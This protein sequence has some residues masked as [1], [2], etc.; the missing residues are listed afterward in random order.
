MALVVALNLWELWDCRLVS[1]AEGDL[2]VAECSG[3]TRIFE[4]HYRASGVTLDLKS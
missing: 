3:Q 1:V 4:N 2:I